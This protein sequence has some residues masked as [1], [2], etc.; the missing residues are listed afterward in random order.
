MVPVSESDDVSGDRNIAVA[1][2]MA[3]TPVIEL[4][5]TTSSGSSSGPTPDAIG[6]TAST[7]LTVPTAAMIAESS[8]SDDARVYSPAAVQ[9]V[10]EHR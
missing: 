6:R 7:G 1:A 2:M 9:V 8:E 3:S 10:V 4:D 5:S